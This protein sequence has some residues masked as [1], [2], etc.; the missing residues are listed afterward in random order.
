MLDDPVEYMMHTFLKTLH[1]LL[2]VAL[3]LSV[4]ISG[5][6]VPPLI[7]GDSAYTLSEWLM[8]LYTDRGNLTPEESSFNV[9]HSTMQVA[10]ENAF[11]RLKGRLRSISKRLDL[12]AENSCNVIG[13][14]LCFAQLL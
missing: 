13:R 5:V 1:Y 3:E 2:Y 14:L 4:M 11:G 9:K 8:K 7:L 12:N 6:Q 10:V